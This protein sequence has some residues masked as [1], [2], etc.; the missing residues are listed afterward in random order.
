MMPFDILETDPG[1]IS[2]QQFQSIQA[3]PISRW[4]AA[5]VH[6]GGSVLLA[7]VVV[8]L[9]YFLWY[10]QPFFDASGG[11]TLLSIVVGVD[12]ILGPLITLIIF[13]I[14]KKNLKFDLALIAL[15]QI[16]AL[17]YGVHTMYLARPAFV[18]YSSGQF[19]VVPA[20][21]IDLKMLA[22]VSRPEFKS[23]PLMGPKY[24][25]NFAPKS[26]ADLTT[27]MLSMAGL[28]P[29]YYIPYSEKSHYVAKEANNL[30]E[31]LRRKPEVRPV[32]EEALRDIKRNAD[33][34]MYIP[35]IAKRMNLSVL[36]DS[37]NGSILTI[38]KLN[39]W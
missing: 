10:P 27:M 17:C 25:Y 15:I 23:L 28:A 38:L 4:K 33:E 22:Q 6:L 30:N 11:K 14:E 35:M 5:G 9:L 31:L 34:V 16:A 26:S 13:N 32:I 7:L 20:N 39:P 36:V 3:R 18:V 21:H 2:R 24:V 29:Q 1:K 19:M 8:L 12:V 37:K